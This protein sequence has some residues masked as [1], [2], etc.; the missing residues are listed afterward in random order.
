MVSTTSMAFL[1][2]RG[3]HRSPGSGPMAR[4]CAGPAVRDCLKTSKTVCGWAI[5]PVR[6]TQQ[7]MTF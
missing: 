5:K 3:N 2:L 4:Q 6:A 1:G 7:H